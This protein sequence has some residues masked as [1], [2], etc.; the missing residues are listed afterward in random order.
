MKADADLKDAVIQVTDRCGSV[1]PQELEGLV[2]LEELAGVE[3]LDAA[4]E[5]RWRWLGAAGARWLVGC[6]GRLPFRRTSR[7]ARAATGLGRARIR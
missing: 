1:A 7:F 5:L 4:E 2:L 6:A 3:L